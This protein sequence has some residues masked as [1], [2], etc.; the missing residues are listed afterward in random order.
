MCAS[1]QLPHRG[2]CVVLY[3][4]VAANKAPLLRQ[5]TCENS[6]LCKSNF[7]PTVQP[8]SSWLQKRENSLRSNK[9]CSH[10]IWPVVQLWP[11]FQGSKFR[12]ERGKRKQ[13]ECFERAQITSLNVVGYPPNFCVLPASCVV[14]LMDLE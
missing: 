6:F 13:R 5:I 12:Q 9:P 3:S 11:S 8:A 2:V 10:V 4:H 7:Y 14:E 1:F